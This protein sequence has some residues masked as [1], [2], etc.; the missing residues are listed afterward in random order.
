M[1]GELSQLI[2]EHSNFPKKGVIFRDVLPLLQKPETFAALIK[3]MAQSEIVGRSDAILAI[4]SRGFIFG[5]ALAL[6]LSKPMVVARKIGKLP[7]ELF[8]RTYNLEYGENSLSIQ[9]EALKRYQ[10]FVIVDDLLATGGTVRCVSEILTA[11]KKSITG[12]CVVVDL[13]EFN[14]KASLPFPVE[15]QVSL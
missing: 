2:P 14:A 13:K 5:T 6:K 8:T 12:L 1:L 4:D 11:S 10:S 9:K 7:G 3:K 15:S